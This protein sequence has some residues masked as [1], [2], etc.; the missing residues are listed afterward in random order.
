M[1]LANTAER[2]MLD[3]INQER[4]AAGLNPVKLNTLLNDSSEDHSKW[5]IDADIFSHTGMGGSTATERMQAANY[6]FEGSWT[7]GE[8]IAWQSERG[9]EGIA[10]DVAQLHQGLMESPGHRANILNPDFTEIGIGIERGEMEGFDGVV[11]TQNFARTDGDTSQS[12]EPDTGVAPEPTPTPDP[13][14]EP[15]PIPEPTPEP[16]PTPDPEPTP[17]PTPEPE[18]DTDCNEDSDLQIGTAGDDK[19]TAT[20]EWAMVFADAGNDE[21]MGSDGHDYL[22]GE[23]GNDVVTG[24]TGDDMVFG[25]EGNDTLD[26]GEGMDFLI[27]DAGDD[28]MTGGSGMDFF[29]FTSGNDKVTDFTVGEDVLLLDASLSNNGSWAGDIFADNAKVVDGNTVVDFGND[30]SLTLVGVTDVAD[31]DVFSFMC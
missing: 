19:I 15:N 29:D 17:E 31:V 8:N 5:M 9:A 28:I 27:G 10:D 14:P 4:A 6:P 16:E 3:L 7:S 26:G 22:D 13:V 11:V 2:Q 18:P 30:N 12:V 25:G 1:S 24:G 23:A 21:V 20:G